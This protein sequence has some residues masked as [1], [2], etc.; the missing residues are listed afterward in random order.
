[1]GY[2]LDVG[3]YREEEGGAVEIIRACNQMYYTNNYSEE[4]S[5]EGGYLPRN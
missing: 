4:G 5:V 3:L 2:N 1:M